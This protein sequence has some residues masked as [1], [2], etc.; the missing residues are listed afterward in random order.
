MERRDL[1]FG[2][3]TGGFAAVGV[4]RSA[5]AGDGPDRPVVAPGDRDDLCFVFVEGGA[6]VLESA[7][8][9]PAR[10]LGVDDAVALPPGGGHRVADWSPDFSALVVTTTTASQP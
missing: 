9:T 10:P 7:G 8:G 5:T 4:V 2:G 3:P 1:G 6:A